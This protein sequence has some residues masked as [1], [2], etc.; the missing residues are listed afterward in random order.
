L[1]LLRFVVVVGDQDDEGVVVEQRID[2]G[3]PLLL[4]VLLDPLL[5]KLAMREPFGNESKSGMVS[6]NTITREANSLLRLGCAV[7][8]ELA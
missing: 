4:V 5:L 2:G 8:S 3:G 6:Q 1:L 7:I